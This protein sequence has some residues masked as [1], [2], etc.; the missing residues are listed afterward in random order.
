MNLFRPKLLA[1]F[2]LFAGIVPYSY[3][4]E[5]TLITP[6]SPEAAAM[7]RNI[8]IPVSHYT[9]T[10]NINVPLYTIRTRDMEIPI[11]LDYHASG[12]KVQDFAAWVGLGWRLSVPASITRTA[13]RGYDEAGFMAGDGDLVRNGEW[14]EALFD[15]KIDV[16]DGEAD[17]FYF[18]IPGK[19]GTMVW[20]PEKEQFYT[21]PYQN[22]KI[23]YSSS[24][25]TAFAQFRITDEMGNR[26]TFKPSETII[27]D[28]THSVPT[29][30]SL[31]QILTARGNWIEFDYL[32][33]YDLQYSYTTYG[34]TQTYEVQKSPFTRTLKEDD[35][36]TENDQ[37]NSVSPKYLSCI[38][39]R[40]GKMEFISDDDR[41]WTDV[42]TRRL[43]EI[44]LYA[45]TDRY[46]KSFLFLL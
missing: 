45:Q 29:A 18:E 2:L 27:L 42:R 10:A 20:S 1:L 36:R 26:Y 44:K 33:G 21:I 11:Q 4:Q 23:E 3:G 30:W 24:A 16:C 38:R 25:L 40:S 5:Q 12:I 34:G 35:D 46:I 37:G 19:S 14:N 17:L 22:L 28:E 41:A 39:W 32:E 31:S 9:G 13:K 8:N 7:M 15:Q 6:P 43:T